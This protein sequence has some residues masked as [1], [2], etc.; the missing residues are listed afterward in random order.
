MRCDTEVHN[1]TCLEKK[2]AGS[3]LY[4]LPDVADEMRRKTINSTYSLSKI[5]FIPS[6]NGPNA[7]TYRQLRQR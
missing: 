2:L 5:G 7:Q 4:S 3:Q 6:P 1:N